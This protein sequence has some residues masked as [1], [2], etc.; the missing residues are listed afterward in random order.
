MYNGKV[1][2]QKRKLK[3]LLKYIEEIEPYKDLENV[4]EYKF[5]HFHVPS[6]VWIEMPKI[7]MMI[8]GTGMV[9]I[10]TYVSNIWF[11]GE[12]KDF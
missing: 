2:G 9:D 10:K 11:Y 7:T 4:N 12:M 8:F 1:R 5:E 3:K 6:S